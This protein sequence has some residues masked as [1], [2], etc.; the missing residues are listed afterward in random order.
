VDDILAG[1]WKELKGNVKMWWG[2]LTDDDITMI[3]GKR[4]KLV[5]ALQKRYGWE[6]A[7][8]ETEVNTRLNEYQRTHTTR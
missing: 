5:G 4:D 7:R 3:D 8:A 1:S 2:D 6:K